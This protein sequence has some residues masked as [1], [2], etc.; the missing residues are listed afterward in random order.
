M[1]LEEEYRNRLK[2]ELEEASAELINYFQ[3]VIDRGALSKVLDY[4]FH[5]DSVDSDMPVICHT[6][7]S[8]FNGMKSI[9]SEELFRG[10]K[11]E[12][13]DDSL[14]DITTEMFFDW[15]LDCWINAGGEYYKGNAYLAIHDDI[16]SLDLKTGEWIKDELRV[17][18]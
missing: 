18:R 13:L 2:S 3:S 5:I 15:F 8:P 16:S 12:S 17:D 10:E 6:E 1:A 11:F 4:E 7:L 14:W 9:V